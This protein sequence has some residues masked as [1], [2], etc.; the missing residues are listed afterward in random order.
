MADKERIL[1]KG[2]MQAGDVLILTKPLGTGTLFAADM[3]HKAKGRWIEAAV[4]SMNQ[5]NRR[6]A[7]C[8]YANG[9]TAY[10][11]HRFRLARASGGDD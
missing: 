6:A 4:Q 2:G 7:E 8:L 3:Q 10:R 1:R 11:Y 9:A 5:S